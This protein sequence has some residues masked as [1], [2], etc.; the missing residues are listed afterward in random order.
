MVTTQGPCL[1]QLNM[2][3]M[4]RQERLTVLQLQEDQLFK[5]GNIHTDILVLYNR[6]LM[7]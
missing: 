4:P 2:T 3:Q 6:F 7:S 5:S 1:I